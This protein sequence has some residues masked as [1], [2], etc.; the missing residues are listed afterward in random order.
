MLKDAINAW[1]MLLIVLYVQLEIISHMLMLNVFLVIQL[2]L[3][4]LLYRFV[5]PVLSVMDFLLFIQLYAKSV[6]LKIVL[7][8]IVKCVRLVWMDIIYKVF[9]VCLVIF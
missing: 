4:V 6:K 5:L 8:V 3:L 2:V 9:F 7:I 1:V